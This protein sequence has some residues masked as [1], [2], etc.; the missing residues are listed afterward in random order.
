MVV[1]T[2]LC[3]YNLSLTRVD[4]NLSWKLAK[5]NWVTFSQKA[6]SQLEK[7]YALDSD[8]PVAHFATTLISIAKAITPKS[9]NRSVKHETVWFN[10]VKCKAAV[11][12]RRKALKTVKKQPTYSSLENYHPSLS[13]AYKNNQMQILAII[14]FQD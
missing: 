7:A 4:T 6:D 13:Q 14:H 2:F 1:N 10:D 5:A 3:L 11:R 8:G 12:N 9:K